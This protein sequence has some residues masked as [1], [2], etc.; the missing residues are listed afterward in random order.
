MKVEIVIEST[1]DGFRLDVTENGVTLK[2]NPQTY[3]QALGIVLNRIKA[4]AEN[5]EA[6]LRNSG[7]GVL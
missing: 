3:L 5:E 6:K 7:M 4:E 2:E 1:I